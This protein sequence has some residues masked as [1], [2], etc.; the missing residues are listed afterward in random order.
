MASGTIKNR[1][2]IL[3][4]TEWLATTTSP[5]T[6]K[7]IAAPENILNS[8][9][10]PRPIGKPSLNTSF[11]VSLEGK[12]NLENG[13][14]FLYFFEKFMYMI[15]EIIIINETIDVAIPQPTPPSFG[16]PNQP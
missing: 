7:I 4:A 6:L 9:K 2:A 5:R 16:A 1:L 12:E 11:D 15:I 13:S 8:I 10:I 3:I 14:V